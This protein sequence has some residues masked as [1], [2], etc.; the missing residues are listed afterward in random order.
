M[1]QVDIKILN[2]LQEGITLSPRPFLDMARE[3]G[4]SEETILARI[5]ALRDRGLIRRLG[6]VFDSPRMG[7]KSTLCAMEVPEAR[8]PEVAQQVNAYREVTHNYLRNDVYN[9]WF[10]VTASSGEDLERILQEIE[11]YTGIKVISMPVR[12]R[13]K[14]KVAFALNDET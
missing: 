8:I 5:E 12:Q 6:G 1:D 14:I 2:Y 7:M 13:Y 3:L 4:I 11:S 9:M 10:T